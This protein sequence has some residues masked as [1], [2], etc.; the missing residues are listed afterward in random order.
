MVLTTV[1]NS[2][3]HETS[4]WPFL[5][6]SNL[7]FGHTYQT[8]LVGQHVPNFH[9]QDAMLCHLGHLCVPSS[10]RAKIILEAH[11]SGAAGHFTVEKMVVLL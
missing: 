5:Y 11:Y 7:E 2:C 10:E 1:L 9:L 4:N 6:K 3:E 8:P